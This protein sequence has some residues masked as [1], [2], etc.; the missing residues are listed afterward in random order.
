MTYADPHILTHPRTRVAIPVKP[1]Y[2]QNIPQ[3]IRNLDHGHFE[4]YHGILVR[5]P[6]R[7][8]PLSVPFWGDL[9]GITYTTDLN[10]FQTLGPYK[11]YAYNYHLFSR[12]KNPPLRVRYTSTHVHAHYRAPLQISPPPPYNRVHMY[13]FQIICTFLHRESWQKSLLVRH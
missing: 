12:P 1:R 2:F 10:P 8:H 3:Y 5:T 13:M 7:P 4:V 6:K 11:W 9:Q